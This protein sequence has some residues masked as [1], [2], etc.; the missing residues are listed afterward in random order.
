MTYI[1]K[2][3]KIE[4]DIRTRFCTSCYQKEVRDRR[5]VHIH[6]YRTKLKLT[7]EQTRIKNLD[8]ITNG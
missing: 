4:S 3:T 5:D 8:I 6:W 7:P 2:T 1:T